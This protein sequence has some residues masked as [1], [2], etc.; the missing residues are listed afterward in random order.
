MTTET[1]DTLGLKLT[2]VQEDTAHLREEVS[3]ID[4]AVR[5]NGQPGLRR[6]VMCVQNDVEVLKEWKRGIGRLRLVVAAAVVALFGNIALD[7]FQYL[8]TAAGP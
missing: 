8:N 4:V 7:L 6:D 1:L 3:K 2:N 5:G